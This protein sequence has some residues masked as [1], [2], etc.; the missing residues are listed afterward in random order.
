MNKLLLYAAGAFAVAGL[1]THLLVAPITR[2]AIAL[3][4]IEHP[5][6]RRVQ[7]ASVP[8]LGGVAIGM[9]LA[10]SASVV[11]LLQWQDWQASILRQDLVALG[12]GTA[13]VFLV[14]LVD[15]LV[16]VSTAKKF[17]V[18]LGAAFLLVRVGWSFSELRLPLFGEIDLGLLGPAVSLLWIV[19]VTNAINLLDGLDGLAGGVV[20]IISGTLLSLA[21]IQ[22][23]PGTVV[24]MAATAGSCLGFLRHNWQPAKIFMGDAGSL[25]LGFLL[26]AASV[27][28]SIKAPAAV[29]ILVPLLAL[30]LPVFDTLLVMLVRF[31]DRPKSRWAERFLRMF[32]ADRNHIHHLIDQPTVGR[33]KAV[34]TLYG[35]AF[36]FCSMALLVAVTGDST[37]GLLLLALELGVIALIRR[38]GLAARAKRQAEEL[39]EPVE[40]AASPDE[41]AADRPRR[42]RLL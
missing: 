5:G 6:G 14:G 8:R 4:A 41:T 12:L 40:K 31:I 28:S 19:G 17:L 1:I 39:H 32:H 24:L 20:A 38:R 26:A 22:Q 15:D 16:G 21:L 37:L 7:N 10:L 11:A 13:L 30:G 33:P 9:G 25:T 23:N 3:R 35:V 2:L 18:E 42:F 27:H 36:S 34:A 29:A